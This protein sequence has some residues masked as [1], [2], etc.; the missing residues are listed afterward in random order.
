[1]NYFRRYYEAADD[2]GADPGE[3]VLEDVEETI[4]E[5]AAPEETYTRSQ[6]AELLGPRFERFAAH[7]G[8][9][10]FRQ[11]GS[12]YGSATDLIR[13]GAHLSPQ[14]PSVY[15]GIGL[16]PAEI[17]LPAPEPE[18]GP[19]I[20]GVPWAQ[21]TAWDEINQLA[22]S[23][24]MEHKK[25]A[26]MAVLELKDAPEDY[27]RAYF[28]N[29]AGAG[30]YDA[31]SYQQAAIQAEIDRREGE[32]EARILERM[33]PLQQSHLDAYASSLVSQAQATIPGFSEHQ[34][35]VD[36]L[37]R[38]RAE[39]YPGYE[40]LFD[41]K[42]PESLPQQLA[43]LREL[44]LIA[45]ANAAPDRKAALEAA[46]SDTE[47]KKLR[48]RTETSRTSGAPESPADE[49]TRQRREAMRRVGARIT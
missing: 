47:T 36:R 27:K 28:D 49:G 25:T 24:H 43:E 9:E 41:I 20:Y 15:E 17:Q 44:T 38:A 30:Q 45:A 6:L 33:G 11:F 39:R 46:A 31:L 12:A 37:L 48:A 10:A 29:W 7:E 26:A 5:E 40:N 3:T 21:P 19:E 22:N 23:E 2:S 1:M 13:Q 18:Q 42:G 16:D 14:D 8:D 34:V 35:E 4:E 32:L